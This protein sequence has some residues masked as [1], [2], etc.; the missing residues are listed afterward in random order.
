MLIYRCRGTIYKAQIDH[1]DMRGLIRHL[2][3]GDAIWY[4][5]DQD[6]GLKQGVMA[7]FLSPSCHCNRSP[8]F[9]KNLEGGCCSFIFLSSWQCTRP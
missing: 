5:P 1:D 8:S 7:P 6:F 3:E 2:K 4:S 9:I